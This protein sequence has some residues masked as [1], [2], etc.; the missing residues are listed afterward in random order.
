MAFDE[1]SG[2][3]FLLDGRP[4]G[5]AWYSAIDH[6]RTAEGFRAS[7]RGGTPWWSD[8]RPIMIFRRAITVTE[9]SAFNDCGVDFAAQYKVLGSPAQTMGLHVYV[10]ATE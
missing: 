10:P 6:E 1:M 8:R 3:V 4:V 9:T 2:L 7:C 5:E